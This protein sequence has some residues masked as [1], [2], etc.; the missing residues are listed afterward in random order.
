MLLQPF[1]L[2]QSFYLT[3]LILSILQPRELFREPVME[4]MW[5]ERYGSLSCSNSDVVS[6]FKGSSIQFK[7]VLGDNPVAGKNSGVSL[8]SWSIDFIA[9]DSQ[10]RKARWT[11]N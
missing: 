2:F 3:M 10:S 8:G 5:R 7:T 9:E 6:D 4:T 11:Y 1:L